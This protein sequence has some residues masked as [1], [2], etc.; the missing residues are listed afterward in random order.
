MWNK[1]NLKNHKG[2]KGLKHSSKTL[3]K[4]RD[5]AIKRG[6]TGGATKLKGIPRPSEVI[7]IMKRTMFKKGFIPW[8]K[9]KPHLKLRGINHHNWKGG[10]SKNN[11]RRFIMTTLEYKIWRRG[12][13]ERDNYACI[14][15]GLRGGRLV[16]DH[17]KP[18]A[19]FPELRFALDN[20]RTL[21]ETCHKKTD[22][23]GAKSIKK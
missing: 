11:T 20:G 23:Y 22:T 8:N 18:W 15:C 17:I 9:G 16:A 14:W 4:M 21:C 6:D 12:V 2:M 13:F 5:S 1:S 7:K 19:L 10:I 3:V